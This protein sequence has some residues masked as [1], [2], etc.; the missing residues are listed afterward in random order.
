MIRDPSQTVKTERLSRNIRGIDIKQFET[1]C[2]NKIVIQ[3]DNAKRDDM[4]QNY[5]KDI[6]SII[7]KHA[8]ITR[9]QLANRKH[10]TFYDKDAVKQKIQ[11]RRAEKTWYKRQLESDKKHYLH[12]DKYCKKHS[13]H[14]KK[15]T[16]REQLNN[17]NNRS[18]NLYKITKNL[19]TNT[20]ENILP[21][22]STNN[23]LADSFP[24]FFMENINKIR[25][26]FRH[27][28]SCN[29]STRNCN[30]LSNFQTI[31]ED[32]LLN[33]IKTMNSTTCSSD[34]CNTKFILK[35]SKI[36]VPVWTKMI[37]QSLSQGIVLQNWKE[38]IIIPIQKS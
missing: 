2:K 35:F 33:N 25:S 3:H 8:P 12:V 32:E 31:T 6:T 7:E 23:E 10:N 14:S 29:M 18:K 1:D 28:D 26:Q 34:A 17:D 19:T 38:A 4:Y 36:L 5:I 15:K 27:E 16:L 37:N 9:R 22:S 30:I 24:N 13:H 20:K 21:S 11:R